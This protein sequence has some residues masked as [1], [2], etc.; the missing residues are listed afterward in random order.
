MKQ[1]AWKLYFRYKDEEGTKQFAKALVNSGRVIRA[2][3][4]GDG[5]VQISVLLGEV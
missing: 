5:I 2:Y 3:Y 4:A 1:R